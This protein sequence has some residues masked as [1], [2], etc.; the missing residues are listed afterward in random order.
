MK[1]EGTP[2][3]LISAG[4]TIKLGR[5]K[6]KVKEVKGEHSAES[7]PIIA[8]DPLED[9]V[10]PEQND[11]LLSSETKQCRICFGNNEE[12]DNPLINPCACDGSV[13][14]IHFACL[15]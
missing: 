5:V 8:S 2:G 10:L 12:P 13:K 9:L 15:K 14:Y 3:W 6:F 4:D 11:A 1:T 7:M